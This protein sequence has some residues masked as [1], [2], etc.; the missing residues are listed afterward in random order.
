MTDDMKK[1]QQQMLNLASAYLY[2][3][4]VNTTTGR[5][6]VGRDPAL[7]AEAARPDFI[8]EQR[9]VNLWMGSDVAA[10]AIEIP[11]DDTWRKGVVIKGK[12]PEETKE[13]TKY[14]Q[15]LG[16]IQALKKWD[17]FT[18]AY[19]GAVLHPV[20]VQRG[21]TASA[22]SD[23]APIDKIR[24]F[25]VYHRWELEGFPHGHLE[26]DYYKVHTLAFDR[27]GFQLHSTRV[28]RGSMP[29]INRRYAHRINGW[30]PSVFTK[31]WVPIRGY[32]EAWDSTGDLLRSFAQAY[33]KVKNLAEM[34]AKQGSSELRAR[35]ETLILLQS[36]LGVLLLDSD[37]EEYGRQA[38]PVAGLSDILQQYQSRIAHALRMPQTLLFGQSPGG[39]NATGESDLRLYYDRI[40]ARRN[41]E[42]R[43]PVKWLVELCLRARNSPTR[44]NVPDYIGVEFPPLWEESRLEKAQ[45]RNT[46]LQGD[47]VMVDMKAA[48][49]QDVAENRGHS[50][51]SL[52]TDLVLSEKSLK[53][54]E[55][56]AEAVV[57][58]TLDPPEMDVVSSD[59]SAPE[60]PDEE[61]ND[62]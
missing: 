48:L 60:S 3:G 13:L 19:G 41:H 6:V 33:F 34:A 46:L 2:D 25:D 28:L 52:Q 21:S 36:T 55:D 4:L 50:E 45:I 47:K 26:P 44:G 9:V 24:K 51:G 39:L 40:N 29:I 62:E 59:T 16:A 12:T 43:A 1:S 5:G 32:M 61:Q 30:G 27:P 11:A 17:M 14:F 38:T 23:T 37:S 53:A 58:R 7:Q 22:L 15:D 56:M 49:P 8:S 54:I 20:L 42:L 10:N 18:H 31:L 57:E 35:M